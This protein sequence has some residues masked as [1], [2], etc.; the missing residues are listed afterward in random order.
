MF[1]KTRLF[2]S[3]LIAT[4]FAFSY[5]SCD[6]SAAG[7]DKEEEEPEAIIADSSYE[8]KRYLYEKW[9]G[10][11][12]DGWIRSSR[13]YSEDNEKGYKAET[14]INT[15]TKSSNGKPLYLAHNFA[16][17]QENKMY[18]DIIFY[19]DYKAE[20]PDGYYIYLNTLPIEE[21]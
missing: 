11:I 15:Y 12:P 19:F 4:I 14:L 1:S 13:P 21:K 7:S 3:F 17:E 8:G 16:D 9:K 6:D 2:K 20:N 5:V 10:I 18:D